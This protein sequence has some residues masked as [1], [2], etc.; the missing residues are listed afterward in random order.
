VTELRIV[1]GG[2]LSDEELAAI[3]AVVTA[4]AR[5]NSASEAADPRLRL[6]PWVASG[7]VKGTRTKV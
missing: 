3:I 4:R 6:S 5:A 1:H 2:A 7:L